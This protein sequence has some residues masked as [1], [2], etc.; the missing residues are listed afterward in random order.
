MFSMGDRTSD[1]ASEYNNR[2]PSVSRKIRT[3]RTQHVGRWHLAGFEDK[4]QS[5]NNTTCK[6]ETRLKIH[7]ATPVSSFVVWYTRVAVS[8]YG[9]LSREAALTVSELTVHFVANDVVPYERIQ[10]VMLTCPFPN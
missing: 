2:I 9:G 6:T 10:D 3:R 1:R 4:T 8:I 7:F 5:L